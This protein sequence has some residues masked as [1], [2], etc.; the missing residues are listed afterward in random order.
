MTPRGR[1]RRQ[2]DPRSGRLVRSLGHGLRL[3]PIP[4]RLRR[5]GLRSDNLVLAPAS[6]LRQ[7]AYYQQVANSL[8][9]GQI[10]IILPD[11]AT[12]Q[13]QTAEKVRQRLVQRGR[14]VTTVSAQRFL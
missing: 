14:K 3:S 9:R 13:G 4:A 1:E 12:L 11:P 5:R 2:R 7:R 10:L 6:M 8:P